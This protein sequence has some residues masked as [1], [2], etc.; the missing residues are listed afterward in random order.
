[1][2]GIDSVT[3]ALDKHCEA[4]IASVKA[5]KDFM[6][7]Q[8]KKGNNFIEFDSEVKEY[9]DGMVIKD[10]EVFFHTIIDEGWGEMEDVTI[11]DLSYQ[12][13]YIIIQKLYCNS[14]KVVEV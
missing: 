2:N 5:I 6:T 11:K 12:E 3:Q 14:Y 4:E 7:E 9:I 1:M 13:L 8:G 10:G